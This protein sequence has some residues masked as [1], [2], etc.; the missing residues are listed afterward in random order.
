M[1]LTTAALMERNA[2]LWDAAT[3]H[4][5]LD[6]VHDGTLPVVALSRW[7]EQDYLFVAGLTRAWGGLLVGA[8]Q[9]DFTLI[10]SGIDAFTEE[11]VW[12]EDRATSLA[13]RLDREPLPEASAYIEGLADLATGPYPVAITGMWAVE[14]AYLEAWQGASGGDERFAEVVEHWA[15]EEFAGFVA[16]LA[17]VVDRELAASP[18]HHRAAEDAFAAVLSHEASFWGMAGL[19]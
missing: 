18:E 15:N 19:D 9:A 3:R 4:E 12:F 16:E 2:E 14:V 5:F 1:S 13:V 8:P 10:A 7:M 11:L 6:R 17:E